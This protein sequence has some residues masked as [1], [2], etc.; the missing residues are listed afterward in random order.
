MDIKSKPR[1]GAWLVLGG[2]SL[3]ILA[4]FIL[5]TAL[6][7]AGS[8][9]RLF[10]IFDTLTLAGAAVVLLAG[11]FRRLRRLD[12][13]LGLALGGVLG[14]LLPL[15]SLYSP[16]PP[17]FGPVQPWLHALYRAASLAVTAWGGLSILRLG[18]PVALKAA[19][20]D[21]PRALKSL[22]FGALVGLPLALLNAAALSLLNRQPFNWQPPFAAALDALQ[23]GVG[24]EVFYRLTLLGLF[25]LALRKTWPARSAAWLAGV[26]ALLVHNYAHFDAL[27]VEQPLFA[28]AYG[29]VVAL[30]WGLPPTLLALR[31]DLEAAAGFHWMQDALRFLAG[32]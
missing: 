30:L 32:F 26:L 25:W 17:I 18:G 6:A 4:I 20:P 29:A 13:L 12:W 1:A 9:A 22:A 23:P 10:D 19:L 24:E 2:L 21:L 16:Y 27:F 31:R 28:L 14:A 5:R 15:A 3:S 8:P 11:G 7:R